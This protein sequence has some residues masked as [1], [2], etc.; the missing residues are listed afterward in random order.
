MYGIEIPEH[1]KKREDLESPLHL[2]DLYLLDDLK[3]AA[4]LLL[5]GGLNKE[6]IFDISLLAN[7][8]WAEALRNKCVDYLFD[9]A[10]SIDDERFGVLTEGV[11]MASLVKKFVLE[12]KKQERRPLWV[13]KL[14]GEEPRFKK[15]KNFASLQ[16]YGHYVESKISRGSL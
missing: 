9:K 4:G 16:A 13:T 8:S 10:S 11:V 7:K 1:L 15:R 3:N 5:A 2:A 12:T 14:F 6:N